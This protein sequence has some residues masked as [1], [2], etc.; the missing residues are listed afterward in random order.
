MTVTAASATVETATSIT[1]TL[2]SGAVGDWMNLYLIVDSAESLSTISDPSGWV[3]QASEYL[4][5]SPAGPSIFWWARTRQSGDASV[6]VAFPSSLTATAVVVDPNDANVADVQSNVY[7]YFGGTT[8]FS[9][10]EPASWPGTTDVV[11]V[12]V[13]TTGITWSDGGSTLLQESDATDQDMMVRTYSGA[14]ATMAGTADDEIFALFWL[15]VASPHCPTFVAHTTGETTTSSNAHTLPLEVD[16]PA[17][18]IEENLDFVPDRYWQ[19]NVDGDY[20]MAV[21][22]IWPDVATGNENWRQ[23]QTS[24]VIRDM[25]LGFIEQATLYENA[26]VSGDTV[27]TVNHTFTI[28]G[29]PK[30]VNVGV[31]QNT[32]GSMTVTEAVLSIEGPCPGSVWTVGR[33]AWGSRG[34]WH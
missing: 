11:A 33:V 32:G 27:Q 17:V 30:L 28:T 3:Q 9:E 15:A 1:V 31:F 10:T 26:A 16:A 19:L 8:T 6:T 18:T 20:T 5:N 23:R 12:A 2:P 21:T 22:V 25:S 24:L 13:S 34:A 4:P 29:A 7:G 14:S